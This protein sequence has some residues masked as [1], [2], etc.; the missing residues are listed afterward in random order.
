ML[1]LQVRE[2]MTV[3]QEMT[4]ELSWIWSRWGFC[5][6]QNLRMRITVKPEVQDNAMTSILMKAHFF[7]AYHHRFHLK[8]KKGTLE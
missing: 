4:D 3:N 1:M 7:G 6:G 8:H 5:C 2:V